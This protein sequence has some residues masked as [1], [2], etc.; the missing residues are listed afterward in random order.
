MRAKP[1]VVQAGQLLRVEGRRSAVADVE[2]V[3][4]VDFNEGN[5]GILRVFKAGVRV[6]MPQQLLG[7]VLFELN[8]ALVKERR[9]FRA[10][11]ELVRVLY[12]VACLEWPPDQ[13]VE[14]NVD[15]AFLQFRDE[16]VFAIELVGGQMACVRESGRDEPARRFKIEKLEAHAIHAKS[17]QRGRPQ[18][19]IFFRG[20]LPRSLAPIGNIHTPQANPPAVAGGQMPVRHL[21]KSVF[22]RRRVQKK[23]NIDWRVGS[24]GASMI[25]RE[26]NHLRYALRM[27]G[28]QH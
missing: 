28:M 24:H 14:V 7:V 20:D 19:R 13:E 16:E 2:R 6:A 5:C 8:Q 23:R 12:A 3:L 10:F 17:R 22:S 27:S 26:W 4:V 21:N 11:A 9:S 1:L 25:E 18:G 15:S